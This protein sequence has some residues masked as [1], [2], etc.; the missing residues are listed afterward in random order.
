MDRTYQSIKLR[1]HVGIGGGVPSAKVDIRLGDVVVSTP[2]GTQSGVIQYNLGKHIP[3][4]FQRKGFLRPP[5][6]EWLGALSRMQSDHR[7]HPNRVS[8]F[9]SEMLE[10]YPR[11]VE[12]QRPQP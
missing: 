7:T 11:L 12:Y 8:E 2:S 5:P 6:T 9:I 10:T 4:G 3:T 1:L